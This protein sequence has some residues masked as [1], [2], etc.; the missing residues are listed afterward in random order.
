MADLRI[1]AVTCV[2]NEGPFLL[3]WIAFHRVAGVTDF[4]F[5]SNDCTDATDHLLDCLAGHGIVTHL[6]NPAKNRNYQMQ[7]LKAA[8]QHALVKRA[9]WVWIADVDEFPNIHV[10]D[11]TFPALIEACGNPQA[12]SLTFQFM[13]NGDVVDFVDEPV[14]TQF[15]TSHNPDIW[16]P[17]PRSRSNRSS[18]VTFPPIT[19][20]RTGPFMTKGN[21]SQ[22]GPTAPA[23]PFPAPSGAAPTSD[24][25][26]PF[27]PAM[28]AR[29]PRSTTMR[30]ARSTAIWSKNDRG[31][32]NREHRA[33]D[34]S[35]WRERND[36]GH[37]DDSILRYEL[38]LREEIARLKALDGVAALHDEAVRLHR[39]RR[40]A[41][42]AQES[43][44]QMRAQLLDAAPYSAAEAAIRAEIGL[45]IGEVP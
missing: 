7:A 23:A 34:D 40:D 18:D 13:A 28:P 22:Y 25:S 5:Y 20:A 19:L 37:F 26:A 12:I 9:D 43:Y 44:R 21:Q 31:D 27:R 3:D 4:L 33:F 36:G 2:K 14:I 15:V 29:M 1:T 45:Q 32:V 6:P 10:G 16:G 17:R 24:A 41:L 35:Y 39:A 8:K 42:L 38:P 30:C 11:H